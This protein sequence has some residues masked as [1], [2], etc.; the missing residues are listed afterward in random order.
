[1]HNRSL[2]ASWIVDYR[3][4]SHILSSLEFFSSHHTLSDKYVLLPNNSKISVFAIGTVSLE[5]I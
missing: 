5:L 3:A 1:M 4:T 2:S